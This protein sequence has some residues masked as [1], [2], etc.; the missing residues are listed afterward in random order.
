MRQTTVPGERL[1]GIHVHPRA[2]ELEDGQ[3]VGRGRFL[4][5]ADEVSDLDIMALP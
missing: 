4:F 2:V 3:L 5:F 1:W